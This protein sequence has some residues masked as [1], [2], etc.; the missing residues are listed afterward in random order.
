VLVELVPAYFT[1]IVRLADPQDHGFDEGVE[2][3]EHFSATF[4]GSS[5]ARPP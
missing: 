5:T 3:A 4:P 2:V 1:E